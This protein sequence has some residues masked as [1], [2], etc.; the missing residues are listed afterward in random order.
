MASMIDVVGATIAGIMVLALIVTS[1]FNIQALN[2]NTQI[3]LNLSEMAEDLI[4]GKT[5]GSDN[6][7]GLETYL[8]KVGAGVPDTLA[9]IEATSISFKFLGKINSTSAVSTF[10]LVQESETSDGFPLYFYQDDMSN[11]I[12]GPFWLAD[13]LDIT[14]FDISDNA[15]ADP[16]SNHDLIRSAE[17]DLNFFFNTYQPD[18]DKRS[19]RHNIVVWKYFKNL[20]L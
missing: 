14:Y 5:I 6:Y 2:Y 18:I 11:P 19:I 1:L 15:V 7:L 17:I 9:I 20:Y 12:F 8:S 4:T 10:Y 13:S 3:Q 16:N